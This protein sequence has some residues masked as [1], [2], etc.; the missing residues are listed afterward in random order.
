MKT[1]K[2]SHVTPNSKLMFFE[3]DGALE[4]ATY[5]YYRGEH[6]NFYPQDK[7]LEDERVIQNYFMQ[8]LAPAAP[9]L[10]SGDCIVAFGSC[11]ASHISE[12]LDR[13]DYNVATRRDRA[14]Y[15]SKMGDGI[16]NTYAIRQQFEWGWESKQ[17][18]VELWHGY[19]AKALGYDETVRVDTK[20]LFDSA[21]AF[22]ITLGLSEVWYDVPTGEVFWRAIPTEYFDA[23]R[24]K[25][26]VT[27]HQENLN[28]L[29]AIRSLIRKYRPDA[30]IVFTVSPIPLTATFRPIACTV[31]DSA[32]KAILRSALDEFCRTHAGDE[33][34]FYFPSYEISL[35][36]FQHPYMEDRKHLHKHV[37]DLN[38][39]VFERYFC[40]TGLTDAELFER[41]CH[42]RECDRIVQTDGHWAVP[43]ANLAFHAPPAGAKVFAPSE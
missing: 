10:G 16:V 25:F 17:P 42:A 9:F 31:A 19:N 1:T 14:A 39:A 35:R 2:V 24:H 7:S 21:D 3:Q 18:S 32:S 37:L 33:K 15:I 5:T 22:I 8:Q 40:K 11:F 20:Q 34:M 12:Y 36:A 43:R 26:R 6:A 13:L 27:S 23:E 30:A 38:M 28:N 29:T 41:F 4:K